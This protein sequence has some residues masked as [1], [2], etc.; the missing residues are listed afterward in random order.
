[1]ET[2]SG[3]ADMVDLWVWLVVLLCIF[4]AIGNIIMLE[5]ERKKPGF[6]S[7]LGR[8]YNNFL[9]VFPLSFYKKRND[10]EKFVTVY[11]ASPVYVWA[12]RGILVWMAIS[13]S[14]L[15]ASLMLAEAKSG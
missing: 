9:P 6:K 8:P 15:L 5:Y 7:Y 13:L 11:N 14:L 4:A 1:M 2:Q 10:Y 3:A 12:L